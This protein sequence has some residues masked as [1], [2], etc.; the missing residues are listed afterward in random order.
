MFVMIFRALACRHDFGYLGGAG[1]AICCALVCQIEQQLGKSSASHR[2]T[3]FARLPRHQDL[4]QLL[5]A[6]FDIMSRIS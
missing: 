4:E 2:T 3:Q 6:F 5:G 1:W